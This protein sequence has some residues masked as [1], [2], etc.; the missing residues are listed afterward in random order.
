MNGLDSS[1]PELLL[2]PQVEIWRVDTDEHVG[3]VSDPVTNEFLTYVDQLE[4]TPEYLNQPH[5]RETFHRHETDHALTLHHRAAYPLKRRFWV[6]LLQRPDKACAQH[7]SG[8]FSGHQR[9][10]HISG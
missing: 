10:S 1:G 8:R 2:Q 4:Q 5:H 6:L 7:I 3:R 9:D